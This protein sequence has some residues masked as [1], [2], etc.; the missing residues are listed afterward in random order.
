MDDTRIPEFVYD[1]TPTGRING[2]PMKT[3]NTQ[4]TK[5]AWNRLYISAVDNEDKGL[6]VAYVISD[7]HICGV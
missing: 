2:Q 6:A 4:E 3:D 5:Q 7:T 1:C